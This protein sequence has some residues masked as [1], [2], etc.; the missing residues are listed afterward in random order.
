MA[1]TYTTVSSLSA[2]G[3]ANIAN[4]QHSKTGTCSGSS[5][6]V[7]ST[8][9][10]GTSSEE[11]TLGDIAAG[12]AEMVE[13]VNLDATNFVSVGFNTPVVAGVETI[14]IKKGQSALLP[15]P[16]GTLY[17]IADTGTVKILKRAVEA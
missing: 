1:T 14:K 16:S 17:G 2:S 11:I 8:Q 4:E 15:T 9:D 10:I 5:D 12:G 13:L 6:I 3:V 7:D